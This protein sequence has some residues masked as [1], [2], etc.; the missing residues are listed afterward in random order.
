MKVSTME[1][2][3]EA[4]EA[5]RK[6]LIALYPTLL[7]SAASEMGVAV[8]AARILFLFDRGVRGRGFT[9]GVGRR[10]VHRVGGRHYIAMLSPREKRCFQS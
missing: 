7:A 6:V 4:V 10:I 3:L 8:L 5:A 1:L 9:R 2:A